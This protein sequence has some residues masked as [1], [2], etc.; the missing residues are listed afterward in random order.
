MANMELAL[1]DQQ[2]QAGEVVDQWS[3]QCTE[4]ETR[5]AELQLRLDESAGRATELQQMVGELEVALESQQREATDAVEQWSSRCKELEEKATELENGREAAVTARIQME[6]EVA[7]AHGH[8]GRQNDRVSKLE[9][10]VEGLNEQLAASRTTADGERSA[11]AT[12]R[13]TLLRTI[14]ETK[15]VLASEKEKS[16]QVE[17]VRTELDNTREAKRVAMEEHTKLLGR[18]LV[19]CCCIWAPTSIQIQR[20]KS[21][22]WRSWKVFFVNKEKRQQLLFAI[23]KSIVRN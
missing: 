14:E 6:K 10:E 2:K 23:G 20:P 22:A 5:A 8:T 21:R 15:E 13:E 4:L 18:S 1:E 9:A 7:E 17:A 11:W 19:C 12:E 3:S 16:S